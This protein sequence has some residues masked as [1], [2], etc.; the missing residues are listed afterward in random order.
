MRVAQNVILAERVVLQILVLVYPMSFPQIYQKRY[1]MVDQ[2]LLVLVYP[3]SFLQIYQM[4]YQMIDRSLLFSVYPMT[5][6][7]IYQKRYQMVDRSLLFVVCPTIDQ[8]YLLKSVFYEQNRNG[9][10][11]P[12][13]YW[14]Y[15]D[16]SVLYK[17]CPDENDRHLD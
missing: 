7:R 12:P 1:Q 17:V 13:H 8:K 5:F 6:P 15:P 14:T 4:R 16:W 10:G 11:L 3:M 2:S 9:L